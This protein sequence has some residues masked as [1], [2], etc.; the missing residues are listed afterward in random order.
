[1]IETFKVCRRAYQ[2]AFL[3]AG[4]RPEPTSSICKRFLLKALA[5]INRGRVTTVNQVQKFIGQ[6]WPVDKLSAEEGVKAF[7]FVYKALTN[8]VLNPYRPEGAQAV[9]VSL[10]V[11]ARIPHDRVYLEDTFDLILWYPKQKKL[12]FVD[13]HIHPLKPFNPA[14]PSSSILVKQFLAERLQCRWPFEQLTMTFARLGPNGATP[15]SFTLDDGLYR[16]HWPEL[17]KTIEEMK[18]PGNFAPHR[19]E[20]CERCEFL[21]KCNAMG[22][23]AEATPIYR[24]A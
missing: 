24:S 3:K 12:E 7:L 5:E 23:F 22:Q 20:L 14:W 18:D 16:V 11:R 17:L 15:V 2:F 6:H 9:G 1:M 13:F 21:A 10:K 4:E 8:Y 19:S